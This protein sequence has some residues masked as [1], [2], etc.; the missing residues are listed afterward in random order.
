MGM[1][2]FLPARLAGHPA[3]SIW[4]RHTTICIRCLTSIFFRIAP[5][6]T[7]ELLLI[8]FFVI[9]LDRHARRRAAR[10]RGA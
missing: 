3:D 4:P 2:P 7:G 5:T 6:F 9:W 1:R 8:Y 10:L